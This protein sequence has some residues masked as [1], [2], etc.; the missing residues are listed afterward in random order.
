LDAQQL[1]SLDA[2]LR[3]GAHAHGLRTD[4]WTLP[5]VATVIERLT[6]QCGGHAEARFRD[7]RFDTP[8]EGGTMKPSRLLAALALLALVLVGTPVWAV[9][10]L[11]GAY[12][13]TATG[14][15]VEFPLYLVVVQN[16]TTVGFAVLDPLI[17]DWFYGSGTLDA[18]QRMTGPLLYA[19]SSE[20]G[21][22]DLQFGS[23][24]VSGALTIFGVPLVVSG[25]RFF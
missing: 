18:Q 12:S 3:Q 16:E 15:G 2:A 4:L 14:E 13:L 1:A 25:A 19:D 7:A 10:P 5:R 6:R 20:A 21:Q 22:F 9:D 17:A 24:S 23:G 11:A 8:R